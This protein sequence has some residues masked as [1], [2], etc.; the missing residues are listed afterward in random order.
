MDSNGTWSNFG[1][2]P[3][4][5]LRKPP[6]LCSVSGVLPGHLSD[7]TRGGLAYQSP[8]KSPCNSSRELYPSL[9]A[10]S[11][12]I[13]LAQNQFLPK[14][15]GRLQT[16]NFGCVQHTQWVSRRVNSTHPQP[17]TD[18]ARWERSLPP[19]RSLEVSYVSMFLI[20]KK[21]AVW[22]VPHS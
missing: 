3:V 5:L 18:G 12:R 19:E 6:V 1:P 21:N 17:P 22:N 15:D 13:L 9:F 11:S 10:E 2:F 8:T 20:S 4:P 16:A 7:S 14:F